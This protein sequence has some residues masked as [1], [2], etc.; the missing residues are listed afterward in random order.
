MNCD[1]T[2]C[3]CAT[4]AEDTATEQTAFRRPTFNVR[5]TADAFDVEVFVPGADR[6]GVEISLEDD[7]L[8]ITARRPTATPESWRPLR[9]EIPAEDYQ[10]TLRVN[11]PVDEGKIEARVADGV[12]HVRLPKAEAV[13]PLRIAVL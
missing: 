10:L 9:R 13:K 1:N 3:A 11:V 4:T 2:S 12:L 8:A 5:E 6:P 7:V